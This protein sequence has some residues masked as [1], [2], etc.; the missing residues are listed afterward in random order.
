M[1]R[2]WFITGTS[3]GFGRIMTECLL[4][5]GDT[6]FATLRKPDMLHD[7]Q[8]GSQGRLYLAAL[9][10][11]DTD[12]VRQVVDQAFAVLGRIDV[13]VSNAGYGLFGAAEEVSDAQIRQQLDT[14]ILGSIT[15]VRA[16][17]PHLRAQGGGRIL[18][19]SSMG[20]QIAFPGLGLYHASKWAIEGFFESLVQE[21]ASFGIEA[22]LIEPGAAR[23]QFGRGSMVMAD[24]LEAYQAV[25]FSARRAV[26]AQDSYTPIG[27]PEKM[28]HEMIAS[29]DVSPAPLR[30]ALGSDAY[31]LMHAA[32]TRRLEQLEAQ[33][34]IALSTDVVV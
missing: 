20:G 27:D 8:A 17:L 25:S 9:D 33:K 3:S 12:M 10:V 22:T 2:N 31:G 30:L 13:I 19:L 24:P 14:N 6:V 18:Q 21:I 7:L 28:V 1:S 15:V 26:L 5:R 34:D 16:A 23:T 4:E 32:L 11:T 29:V